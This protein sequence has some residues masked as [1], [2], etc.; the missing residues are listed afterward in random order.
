M[1]KAIEVVVLSNGDYHCMMLTHK[2]GD[3]VDLNHRGHVRSQSFLK[4]SYWI[5]T[6]SPTHKN[7]S[8]QQL[9]HKKAAHSIRETVEIDRPGWINR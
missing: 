3:A 4:A 9:K 6:A 2:F 7:K 1:H 5:T 8:T